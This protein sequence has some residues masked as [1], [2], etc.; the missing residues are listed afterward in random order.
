M[1]KKTLNSINTYF[2]L[3]KAFCHFTVQVLIYMPPLQA[4]LYFTLVLKVL[5]FMARAA[6]ELLSVLIFFLSEQTGG[7]QAVPR[8]E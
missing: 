2:L 8:G 1:R 5:N 3:T 4:V 6:R 7:I